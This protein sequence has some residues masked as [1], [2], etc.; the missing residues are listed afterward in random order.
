VGGFESL[1]NRLKEETNLRPIGSPIAGDIPHDLR[2]V[3]NIGHD[4]HMTEHLQVGKVTR[5]AGYFEGSDEGV[6]R[7][8]IGDNLE[9][10]FEG[11]DLTFDVL[12]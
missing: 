2:E 4:V 7:V 11:Y 8:E 12:L 6:V 5:D 9:A 10:T 1:V 3:D